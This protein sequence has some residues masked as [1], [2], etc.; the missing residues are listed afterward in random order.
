MSSSLRNWF[1]NLTLTRKFHPSWILLAVAVSAIL[2]AVLWGVAAL[3]SR[4]EAEGPPPAEV[5]A[6]AGQDQDAVQKGGAP[7]TIKPP[8]VPR[9]TR[10]KT[11]QVRFL[12][13][14][15]AAQWD[16]LPLKVAPRLS[17]VDRAASLHRVT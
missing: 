12:A 13:P 17:P 14:P 10:R 6:P 15:P 9:E 7:A 3:L 2:A 1:E 8:L 4:A 11:I 5:S 16:R